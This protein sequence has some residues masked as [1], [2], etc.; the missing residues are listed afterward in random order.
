M[1]R[2][3]RAER[4]QASRGFCHGQVKDQDSTSRLVIVHVHRQSEKRHP[5]QADRKELSSFNYRS[6][7]NA[8]CSLLSGPLAESKEPILISAKLRGPGVIEANREIT[9]DCD[10]DSWL[11]YEPEWGW[12]GISMS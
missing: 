6:V 10:A 5:C 8:H 4:V 9:Q 3:A 7:L 12:D 11:K 1:L 2:Q